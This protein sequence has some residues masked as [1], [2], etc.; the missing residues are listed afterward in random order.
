MPKSYSDDLR[1]RVVWQRR[2]QNKPV[3]RIAKDLYTSPRTVERWVKLFDT[4]G[5]VSPKEYRHGP[6]TKLSEFEE[7]TVLQSL[8]G[9]PGMYLH[10]VQR[11]L[12]DITGTWIDCSTLCHYAHCWGLTRQMTQVALQRSEVKRAEYLAEITQFDPNM[13]IFV[14]ETGSDRRNSVLT[15]RYGLKG[16]PPVNYH[17]QVYGKRISAIGMLSSR[18]IEDSYLVEGSVNSE[19]FMKFVDNSLAPILLLFDGDNPTSIVVFD[20][21]SIH[22]V[23]QVVDKITATGAL[24][25]FL[26]PY[27]PDL[28]PIE[29]AFGKVKAFLKQNEKAYQSTSSPRALASAFTTVTQ[30]DCLGYMQHSGYD[31]H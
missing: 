4:T 11:E 6:L 22:H 24:V 26:P 9:N 21:A 18:G 29:L 16:T 8:L 10:E 23:D 1:W 7:I 15:F 27:S 2:L 30:E 17:L 5:E 14:D 19:C 25:R 31:I 12:L 28:N 13:L 3:V 20:N